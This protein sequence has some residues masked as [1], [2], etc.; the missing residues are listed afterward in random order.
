MLGLFYDWTHLKHPKQ[1]WQNKICTHR[2]HNPPGYMVV[3]PQG[4]KHKCP[5]CGKEIMLYGSRCV[6]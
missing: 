3:G 4:Y 5:G 6:L 1:E 2:Q